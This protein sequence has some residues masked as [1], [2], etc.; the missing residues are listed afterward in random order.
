M[1]IFS[2][3]IA[4][5]GVKREGPRLGHVVYTVFVSRVTLFESRRNVVFAACLER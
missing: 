3:L 1:N 2:Q 5:M 4:E